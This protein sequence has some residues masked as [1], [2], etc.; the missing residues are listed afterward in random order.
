M[1]PWFYVYRKIHKQTSKYIKTLCAKKQHFFIQTF[2]GVFRPRVF[3]LNL[4]VRPSASGSRLALSLPSWAPR[5]RQSA[6]ASP[7][8]GATPLGPGCSAAGPRGPLGA[9]SGSRGMNRCDV[10][11]DGL[12]AKH[13]DPAVGIASVRHIKQRF[14]TMP[15]GSF[16]FG[17]FMFRSRNS[18]RSW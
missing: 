4:Y 10:I 3:Y 12:C 13:C 1:G 7:S 8:P 16:L 14:E 2:I 15:T 9:S 11:Y 6:D 17:R 18:F 5:V